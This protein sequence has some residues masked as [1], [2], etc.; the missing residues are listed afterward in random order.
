MKLFQMRKPREF[1]HTFIYVKEKRKMCFSDHRFIR[2]NGQN[3]IVLVVLLV[4]LLTLYYYF[5]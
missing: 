1:K 2:K 5:S 4:L 3:T